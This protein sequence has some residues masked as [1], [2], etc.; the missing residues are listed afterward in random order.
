MKPLK[1]NIK[2]FLL[3]LIVYLILFPL[4]LPVFIMGMFF[5]V[6]LYFFDKKNK[7]LGH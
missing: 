1:F 2:D 6:A 5:G 7:G 3:D 4:L